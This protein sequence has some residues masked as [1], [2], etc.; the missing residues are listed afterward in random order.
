MIELLSQSITK[1]TSYLILPA[2][3]PRLEIETSYDVKLTPPL[4]HLRLRIIELVL[5]L[6]KL[7]KKAILDSLAES[8]V[9]A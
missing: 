6:I 1:F 4:G 2:A 3:V 9:F 5:Q 7:N 8:E